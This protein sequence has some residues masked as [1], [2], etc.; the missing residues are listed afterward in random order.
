MRTIAHISDIH[1]GK[2]D[3]AVT[4]ALAVEL[5]ERPPSLVVISGDLTQ[6]ARAGQFRAARAFLD[7]L[8]RPQL[9][10]PGN[11]DIPLFDVVRR[12]FW[13]LGNYTRHITSDLRPFYSDEEM[14]VIG[15][16]TA[17]SFSPDWRAF[18]KGGRISDEQLLDVKLRMS[19]PDTRFHVVVTHHPFL[20]APGQPRSDLVRRAK[21][22]LAVFEECGVD[23]LLAGHLHLNYTGEIREHHTAVKRSILSIHAG[24]AT[25]HRHRGEPNSYN[26]ITIER[27]A[28]EVEVR[29]WTGRHFAAHGTTRYRK[30]ENAWRRVE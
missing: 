16:N 23:M 27:E 15:I 6:R 18:W 25:S 4:E 11:H 9:V 8:P 28:V 21:Q 12:A 3:E 26:R 1:F 29:V 2:V 7:R 24:T 17:R 30:V 19:E 5:H 20:P 14:A 10:V 13:P 22:A